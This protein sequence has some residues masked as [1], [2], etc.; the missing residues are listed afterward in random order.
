MFSPNCPLFLML[1]FCI[2]FNVL[3]SFSVFEKIDLIFYRLDEI[4]QGAISAAVDA[5]CP[6]APHKGQCQLVHFY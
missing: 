6:S 3:W 1:M 4:R 5:G 2:L